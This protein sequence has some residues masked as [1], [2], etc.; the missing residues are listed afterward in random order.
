MSSASILVVEDE[1]LIAQ[2]LIRSLDILGYAVA[3]AVPTGEEAVEAA[4]RLRPDLVLMDIML[5]GEMDGA[6]AAALI[7]EQQDLPVIFITAYTDDAT[8][9]RVKSAAPYGYL[10]KPFDRT[11]LR[12]AIE[13]ALSR[14][15]TE[16]RLAE[17]ERRLAHARKMEAVGVLAGGLAHD[18]NNILSAIIGYSEMALG[19]LPDADPVRRMVN[20]IHVAGLRARN[21]VELLLAFS[22]PG[23]G[24]AKG[25]ADLAEVAAEALQLL[26]PSLDAAVDL[27]ADLGQG[28]F[29]VA[30][31]PTRLHQVVMNLL[32]N[33]AEAVRGGGRLSV[34]LA[35]ESGNGGAAGGGADWVR[36]EVADTGPGMEA[37][38]LERIFDPFFTTKRPGQGTGMGLAVVHGVVRSLG[39]RVDVDSSP[40][41][42]ARFTVRLPAAA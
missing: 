30:A 23:T 11:L 7:R 14:R 15:E 3:G 13:T 24:E 10:V 4:R 36:L 12:V 28:R 40:G 6:R 31:D 17:S 42:G 9:D 39:G 5:A 16:A 20:R 41:Q 33:A 1:P 26:A 38:V 19:K 8:L 34:T 37:E 22:R 27:R 25:R 29:P 21:L 18:F 32:T 2:D 35:R